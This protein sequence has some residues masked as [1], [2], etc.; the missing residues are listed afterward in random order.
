MA[1]TSLMDRVFGRKK[2]TSPPAEQA[3]AM[4]VVRPTGRDA[5]RSSSAAPALPRFNTSANDQIGAR[6]GDRFSALRARIRRAFTPS[7]PIA[8]PKMFAGREAVLKTIISSIEDQKLHLVLYGERGIGKTSLMHMIAQAAQD[9]RYIVIYT[10]CGV[11]SDFDETLRAVASEIPLLYHRG[12]S[13][14]ASEA[15]G[16]GT[17]ADLLP[18]TP[19]SPRQFSDLC[20]KLTG[21]RVLIILDEFDRCDS[22]AFRRNIAELIKNLSDRLGRVQLLLAGVAGDLTELVEHIPSIRRNILALNLPRMTDGEVMQLVAHGER[23]SGLSFE[24]AATKLIVSVAQGSPYIASLLSHH[25]ALSAIEH[26][27]TTVLA[28]DVAQAIGQAMAEFEGR[29]AKARISL[30][31]KLVS[32]GHAE[33]LALAART[34]LNGN[35]IF[36]E[37]ELIAT[38]EADKARARAIMELLRTNGLITNADPI[39]AGGE[40]NAF[41]FVE[42]GLPTYLWVSWTQRSLA[43]GATRPTRAAAAAS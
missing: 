37:R 8:D 34:A 5:P 23:E 13:P 25:A 20:T 14:T 31:G 22:P 33:D 43:S 4:T 17:L 19:I 10:S 27:R 11:A 35:G 30:I 39:E 3:M 2:R 24:T 16:G 36:S 40:E 42:E 28:M 12:F 29:I 6:R 15:E 32:Q 1:K 21:T 18:D 9:A 7:Q 38:G 41:T 26:E